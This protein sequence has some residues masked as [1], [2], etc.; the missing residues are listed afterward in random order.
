MLPVTITS[1]AVL[2][3]TAI[4]AVL[5][6]PTFVTKFSVFPLEANEMAGGAVMP[7]FF[8]DSVVSLSLDTPKE[9][10]TEAVSKFPFVELWFA[11]ISLIGDAGFFTEIDLL[12]RVEEN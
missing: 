5:L 10:E 8:S 1:F 7:E 11:V 6:N 12:S 2:L 3:S 9:D 4:D